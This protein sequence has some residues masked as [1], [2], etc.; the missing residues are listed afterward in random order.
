MAFLEEARALLNTALADIQ[1]QTE[2]YIP[3]ILAQE[4][5]DH[6]EISSLRNLRRLVAPNPDGG[7]L[8]DTQITGCPR[9]IIIGDTGSGKSYI[10][11]HVFL[12]AAQAFLASANSPL[13]CFLDLKRGLSN[14]PSVEESLKQVL[15]RR[16]LFDRVSSEHEAGCILFLDALD[17]R[18]LEERNDYSFV[19]GLFNFIQDL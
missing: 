1:E 9:L 6:R 4:G 7:L 15:R 2:G 10:L 5:L 16:Y 8:E 11:Q 13:P 3:R 19:N 12:N 14:Q 17:E 18:L